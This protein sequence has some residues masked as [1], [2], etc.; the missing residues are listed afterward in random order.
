MSSPSA[1]PAAKSGRGMKIAAI[2]TVIGVAVAAAVVLPMLKQ[3][4]LE[5]KRSELR[6]NMQSIAR[7]LQ[8]QELPARIQE[9]Y[10]RAITA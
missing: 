8:E 2:T 9:P 7:M 10:P 4:Q 1:P 5:S 3:Q 6:L